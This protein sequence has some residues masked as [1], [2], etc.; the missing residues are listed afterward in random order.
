MSATSYSLWLRPAAPAAARFAQMIEALSHRLGTPPFEPHLTLSG[1]AS[2]TEAD[3][4]ARSERLA[5]QLAPVP[6]HL[7]GAGYT[8]A[9]FRCLFLRA[10]KTPPLLA[11]HRMASAEMQQ[12]VDADFMPH[13]SL[14]YGTLE[15]SVKEKIIEEIDARRPHNFLADS[16]SLC[17]VAGPPAEW[18]LLGPFFLTGG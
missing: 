17:I 13:L 5:A 7:V 11:A 4:I 2:T 15:T 18:R 12:P 9:Y 14:V 8:D 6:I 16:V 10:E 1:V 3:A